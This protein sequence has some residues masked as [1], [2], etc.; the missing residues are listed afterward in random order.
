MSDGPSPPARGTR[1]LDAVRTALRRSI[2]A[3]AGNTR[4]DA[5]RQL[6]APVHPRLRGEHRIVEGAGSSVT[7]PSPPARGTPRRRCERLGDRRSIPACA[8]NTG[9]FHSGSSPAPVH[10][11]LRG[12]HIRF[13]CCC[14]GPGGPSPPARGT[15]MTA[16]TGIVYVRSIPA[17][18]GN[19]AESADDRRRLAVHPRLRGE[20]PHWIATSTFP[21]GP[22]PPARGT[23]LWWLARVG[24]ERS[25]PACAGNTHA[26]RRACSPQAVH[27]RLRGEHAHSGPLSQAGSGPSPPARG[28]RFYSRRMPEGLR[29]IPACAGNTQW[30]AT[31]APRSTVH[32]RLRGEHAT[33]AACSTSSAGPSP[34]ARG[35]RATARARC[36]SRRSIP[37][38]AGN[39]R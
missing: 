11:R 26:R 20:H 14:H 38:C 24:Y 10:P 30:S 16:P 36:A 37:A 29:S 12:E 1:W 2:P 31:S 8:G 23:H 7:G 9:Q 6:W 5:E 13:G 28:T 35:T 21:G 22:S 33:C 39:T 18:A 27:P 15:L 3:C 17:C 19:T 4:A 34:P 25:I 32:P